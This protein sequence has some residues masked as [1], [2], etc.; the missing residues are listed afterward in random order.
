M[1][2]LP[3]LS[4]T[5]PLK[6]SLFQIKTPCLLTHA[7]FLIFIPFTSLGLPSETS[8]SL[9][10]DGNGNVLPFVFSCSVSESISTFQRVKD[11]DIQKKLSYSND[12]LICLFRRDREEK[13][14]SLSHT[15]THSRMHAPI[16]TH[17]HSHT[18]RHTLSVTHTHTQSSR[19][20][21]HV[22]IFGQKQLWKQICLPWFHI[23]KEA[24]FYTF[25][26]T[27]SKSKKRTLPHYRRITAGN[28]RKWKWR[29]ARQN[30]K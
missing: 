6:I 20:P 12:V 5:S 22:Q 21:I 14:L 26:I 30:R 19:S 27:L 25:F 9:P 28:K 13:S 2:P 24:I 10:F 11:G 15:H 29:D 1:Q 16:H 23:L 3:S 7:I 18:L 4:H 8:F 17:S